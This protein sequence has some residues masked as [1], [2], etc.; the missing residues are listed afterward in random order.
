MTETKTSFTPYIPFLTLISFISF[1]N[2]LARVIF[3]PLTPF[4][5]S[6]MNLCHAD[7][8]NI[9]F[10]LSLG[11]AITLFASQYLSAKFSHKFTIIFSVLTTGFALMLTA[12]A[13]SFEQFR[14]AIFVVGVS[15]GF[16]IP[17]AVALIRENVPNHHLGKAFGIFGTAQSFAFILGPLFV[18]FF[19]Q[20]Y[21]WR[22]ILNGFGLLSA[23]LS[24]ILLFMIRRKEE[25]SVPITF[26]FARE[27]FSRPSFWIINL[28]LCI[29][30]GLNI[31]IYNM[32]PDY[33][34]RHNLLEAHEVN[35]LII[36]ARTISIFTA[37]V[38]GYVADRLGLKKSLVIILVICGT[39]TAMM[40]MT[41]PLL[42]L[43]LFCI[44]SP[45]AAC[46][47]PIIHYGVATIATPEKNAAM[48]SIMAPF[49][50]TF[51]AGI[52]P[53]VLGF[54]GDS[55]L[56]AEGFVIFGVTSLLCALVFSLNAVYKH[57]YLSQVKSM[58]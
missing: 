45:I 10:V 25:K 27:V 29:I 26:S 35:H 54:F 58:E 48:V 56:Y 46:L 4:I 50:F 16:F 23:V 17:S 51:G 22:G 43:L 9:F 55:N 41:N 49:G 3:S 12:Y 40:G 21:N 36:I 14:W 5:C 7:T 38:G 18:Q 53:Q 15:A 32:A 31:G 47:M 37:I 19:I 33:F 11:F 1:V 6:E 28:L 57:V 34:E 39:V 52:V 8:G 24:L 44:Q 30:N 2:I 42:A 20:F 13:N